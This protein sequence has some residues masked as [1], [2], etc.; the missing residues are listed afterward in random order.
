MKRTFVRYLLLFI[1]INLVFVLYSLLREIGLNKLFNYS[2]NINLIENKHS[3]IIENNIYEEVYE[4][5]FVSS[6]NYLGAI[7]IPVGDIQVEKGKVFASIMDYQSREEINKSIYDFNFI[8]HLDILTIGFPVIEKSKDRAFKLIVK[9]RGDESENILNFEDSGSIF[10][11]YVF[12]HQIIIKEPYVLKSIIQSKIS[13]ALTFASYSTVFTSSLMLT[14]VIYYFINSTSLKGPRPEGKS[15]GTFKK[16]L[17]NIKIDKIFLIFSAICTLVLVVAL[18][19]GKINFAGIIANYIWVF[20]FISVVCYFI[21]KIV[22]N[23]PNLFVSISNLTSKYLGETKNI[24]TSPKS[25]VFT[26]FILILF[27]GFSR[28]YQL[29]GD[30]TKLYFYYP[31]EFLF[32]FANKIV[33]DTSMSS[34]VTFALPS[35]SE[36]VFVLVVLK[37]VFGSLNLQTMFYTANLLGGIVSFYLLLDFILKSK[38]RMQK[39]VN[40]VSSLLYVFSTYNIYTLYNSKLTAIFLV[41]T[42]PL[43]LYL[44]LRAILTKKPQYIVIAGII[45]SVLSYFVLSAPWFL[46]VLISCLPIVGYLIWK[47]K[48]TTIKYS[49]FFVSIIVIL[50][51]HSLFY[52]RYTAFVGKSD[53]NI[54]SSVVSEDFRKENDLGIRRTSEINSVFYP[55]MNTYHEMIQRNNNWTFYSIFQNYSTKLIPINLFYL[56]VIAY[57]GILIS[58]SNEKRFLYSYSFFAYLLSIYLFT[59]NITSWGTDIFIWLNNHIPGFVLFRNMY[60]K[61][62]YAVAFNFSLLV[63]VSMQIV[64]KNIEKVNLRRLVILFMFFSILNILPF[65]I[66]QYENLPLWT[67]KH[68]YIKI[69]EFNDDFIDLTNY[70]R[71]TKDDGKYVILPLATGNSLTVQDKYHPDYYYSGTSPLLVVTGKNDFSGL[72]SFGPYGSI[73]RDYILNR[74]FDNLGM[75]FQKLN[76][77]YIILNSDVSEDLKKSFVY[78]DGF[79]FKQDQDM[80]NSLLGE[81]VKDFG[82]RYS[83]YKINNRFRSEKIYIGDTDDPILSNSQLLNYSKLNTYKYVLNFD[84]VKEVKNI[85]FLEPYNNG[86]NLYS[87]KDHKLIKAEKFVA[88]GYALGWKINDTSNISDEEFE[89][90]FKPFDYYIYLHAVSGLGYIISIIYVSY[91]LIN[92]K[93]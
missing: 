67:T 55:L 50:N 48:V 68:T 7:S 72:I 33:S 9:V 80:I 49:F 26:I 75:L 32:N 1:A 37:S 77:N 29:G 30:D 22:D 54:R 79:Y 84:D 78:S 64:L 31:K 87:R 82:R 18:L 59:V 62:G 34:I 58:K 51:I 40:L 63:A 56:F 81:K 89:I 71:N 65:F 57:A 14:I 8:R 10:L 93:K 42:F 88:N 52:L 19:L 47:H 86:W 74:D 5:D 11:K 66:G 20:L 91:S 83:L 24:K 3:T 27:S 44:F 60:D 21:L 39:I 6:D 23:S 36:F 25:L 70:I 53:S 85:I 46:A 13:N 45:T 90:Y 15:N 35:I 73:V 28:T 69:K 38:T 43:I 41:S 17:L 92:R 4:I 76:I 2:S 61:F 12:P 16:I